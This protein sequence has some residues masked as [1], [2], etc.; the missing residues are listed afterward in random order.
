MGMPEYDA[1]ADLVL[2]Y[3]GVFLD[4]T[5]VGTDFTNGFAPMPRVI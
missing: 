4:T 2:D 5:M 1:F 3:A